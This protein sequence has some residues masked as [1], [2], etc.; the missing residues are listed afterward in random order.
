MLLRM[1]K[2]SKAFPGVQALNKV[3]LAVNYGQICALIGENGAGKSTLMKILSGVYQADQGA[4]YLRDRLIHL[5]NPLEAAE[6]GI[7]II[8]QEFNLVPNLTVAENI[9]LGKFPTRVAGFIDQSKLIKGSEKLLR[10]IAQIPLEKLVSELSVAEMQLVE[11]ARAFASNPQVLVMDEPTAALT[12]REIRRLFSIIRR[13]KKQGVA[14]IYIS[15]RL[16]EVLEIADFCAVLRDGEMVGIRRTSDTNR[17][18]LIRLMVGRSLKNLSVRDKNYQSTPL[19]EMKELSTADKLRHISFRLHQGE[20][21]GVAGLMG[22]GQYEL[23]RALFGVI[24]ISSG[25]I[26]LEGQSVN[27]ASPRDAIKLGLGFI[28]ENRKEEG[29]VLIQSVMEN[30]GLASLKEL[31][32]VGGF[33]DFVKERQAAHKYLRELGI[34]TPS[35]NQQISHLSG[36]NQQKVVLAKWLNTAPRVLIMGEPT[37]GIDVGA[38]VEIYQIINQLAAQ[39]KAILLISSELAELLAVCDRILVMDQG[40]ITADL[41]ASKTTQEEIMYY[42]TGGMSIG[43]ILTS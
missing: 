19:L 36:G 17:E 3:D 41:W 18:D 13:L 29:L 42:A 15:H 24:P 21:L 11:I 23:T 38:K 28:T 8:H 10:S 37:R 16:E 39:G 14:I 30:I 5:R 32:R 35:L 34:K 43:N 6:Q 40:A 4:I 26:L 27:I 31:V 2:V 7:A 33:M 20:V 22:A 12:G 9:Y 25:S 1:E